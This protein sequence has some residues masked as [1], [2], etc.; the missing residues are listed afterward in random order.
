MEHDEV[1][2]TGDIVGTLRYM[3]PE[4]F[5][6]EAD[7]RS[8]IY[9]LGL[10]LYELLTLRPAY[11]HSSPSVLMQRIADEQPVRPRAVNPAIPRD[12]ET[13][14]LKAIAR[15]P[16][17]RYASAEEL[18]DDLGRFLDDRPIRARRLG[19]G[20]TP[21]AVVAPQSGRGQP[22][23]TCRR[24]A[25]SGRRGRD[26]GLRANH[27][28]Q[29][30][31]STEALAGQSQQ[32]EKAEAV[33]ALTLE[34][35][36]DIFEQ[37]VPNRVAADAE[38][39]LGDSEGSAVR[40]AGATGAV[41]RGRRP[42]GTHAGVLRSPGTR[43]RRRRGTSPQG[44][45]RQ[46]PRG[47]Y[48][49]PLG[50]FRTG[51]GG[52]PQGNRGLRATPARDRRRSGD[53]HAKSRESTTSLATC[54]G[55]PAGRETADAS[56]PRRWRFSIAVAGGTSRAAAASVRVGPD[57]LLSRPRTPAGSGSRPRIA[58]RRSRNNAVANR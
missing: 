30:R 12:L 16:A 14:V 42:A 4:R 35:L 24:P 58:G 40:L 18:A 56:M 47:R 41:E 55:R 34:A 19:L 11:E 38:P 36:D 44:C 39:A 17:H 1:S 31:K 37:Y 46:P 7:A 33:S 9:S 45:R 48:P 22:D 26:R 43:E 51:Q 25:R 20:G 28:C 13:I 2:Q 29:R 8:D 53:C 57:V 54:I 3:A 10:T 50:T 21:L 23:R 32:R 5:H 49:S 15:E 27:P 52:L 6:G